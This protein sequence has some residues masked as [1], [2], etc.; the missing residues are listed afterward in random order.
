MG[1]LRVGAIKAVPMKWSKPRNWSTL[2]R[3][4]REAARR[5]ARIVVTPE[6]FLDGY[7]IHEE[8]CSPERLKRMAERGERGAYVKKLMA[9]AHELSVYIVGGFTETQDGKRF[10]NAAWY[11]GPDGS[12]T[13][14]YRKIHV[15][16]GYTPGDDL[17]VFD[18][19]W[20]RFGTVICA[21]RRWPENIRTLAVKGARVILM[22]T[23]GMWDE[24]NECWMRTRAYENGVYVCFVHPNVSLIVN[25]TGAIEAKLMGNVSDVLVHDLD[26][27]AAKGA[28]L[29][30]RRPGLYKALVEPGPG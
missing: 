2:E 12:V 16:D 13:G 23:Y 30:D 7:V 19:P 9:L 26:L 21:D 17:P 14:K 11:F 28:H 4:A 18:L 8:D 27:S 5:G 6:C 22:P 10:Y 25:P 15:A 29:D 24:A 20:G 1:K 3:L